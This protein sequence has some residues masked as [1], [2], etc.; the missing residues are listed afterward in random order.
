[1]FLNRM[2]N[3]TG[4]LAFRLT[5]WYAV[6]FTLCSLLALS[7]FYY[8]ISVITLTETDNELVEEIDEFALI[9]RDG[10]AEHVKKYM[11]AEVES[12]EE[13]VFFRLLSLDGQVLAMNTKPFCNQVK[14]SGRVLETLRL[15]A[16]P[17]F[18][19]ITLPDYP[20]SV[21]SVSG[22]ISP[23]LI[24][25]VGISLEQNEKYLK[26]FKRLLLNLIFPL[27]FISA[28]IGWFLARQALKG[29]EE[30]T[31]TAMDISKGD[32]DKRVQVKKRLLEI[33]RL[34][35]TFNAML[36]RIQALIKGMGEITD[37]VA[38]DLRSPLTR[39]RGI[40]EMTL[41]GK[42]TVSDYEKMAASTIEECD[43]LISV[44]NTM[45]DITEIEAG[46]GR[47]EKETVHLNKLLMDACDL[48]RPVADEKNIQL[49]GRMPDEIYIQGDKS[50]LQR[51]VTNLLENAIK[52]TEPGGKVTISA[53]KDAGQARIV[54]SDTGIGIS[55]ADLPKIFERFYRCDN[56]RTQP[57]T[58]LG[59]CLVKAIAMALGGDIRVKSKP[60]EGSTFSVSLPL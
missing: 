49:Q 30:V 60:N 33:N 4:T 12:E 1:M 16:K 11:R 26:V 10:G 36:D 34:A 37:N 42:S 6:I 14:L 52:Y 23:E 29:V 51:M 2:N 28:V 32:Y 22:L 27:F 55:E 21:R 8:K 19:T 3:L 47:F 54:F 25:H 39:I 5:A 48:F 56:S 41:V 43:N 46:V 50:K 58:G 38:H 57:G 53:Y 24:L 44:I 15:Q 35:N 17:V 40:A 13:D 31:Q 7:V 59:L 9:V 45:L 20:Y 18:E